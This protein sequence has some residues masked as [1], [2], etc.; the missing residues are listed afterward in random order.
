MKLIER[1]KVRALVCTGLI[2]LAVLTLA[3]VLSS[4]SSKEQRVKSEW[5]ERSKKDI[6]VLTANVG[7]LNPRCRK[8]L[9][10]L[11]MR[12]VEERIRT[13]VRELDPDIVTFQELLAP[14]QCREVGQAGPNDA[15]T[16][17]SGQPQVRRL[18]GNEYTIVC[19]SRNQFECMGVHKRLGV[20]EGC[21]EGGLC[22]TQRTNTANPGCDNGFT[23]S[24]A[25]LIT[26]S[27][28]RFDVVNTHLQSTDKTCRKLQLE[29]LFQGIQDEPALLR[30]KRV[31]IMGDFNVDPWRDKDESARTWSAFFDAGWGGRPF[32]YHSGIAEQTPPLKTGFFL[33]FGKTV[34]FVVSNFLEGKCATLGET[35]GTERLDKGSGMDH[36]AIFCFLHQDEY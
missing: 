12:D 13:R 36:R 14:D 10:N 22:L 18:L 15:C 31:L 5:T 9:N 35:Q 16:D 24:V 19:N 2:L 25:T 3:V 21:E 1:Y 17:D 30:E 34:D 23:V 6:A 11:C 32:R 26:R 20:F 4:N 29:Q 8:Y 27:G 33:W 7:N 28:L